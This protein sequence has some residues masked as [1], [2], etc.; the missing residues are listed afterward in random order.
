MATVSMQSR[1]GEG[2]SCRA[3]AASRPDRRRRGDRKEQTV[4]MCSMREPV[5]PGD[6]PVV[7]GK[8]R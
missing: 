3:H 7:F 1:Y 8:V 5:R 2:E 4:G 6:Q